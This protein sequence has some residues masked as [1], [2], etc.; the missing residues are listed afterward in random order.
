MALN[1]ADN[2]S[3]GIEALGRQLSLTRMRQDGS[4]ADEEFAAKGRDLGVGISE[5]IS[6]D[7]QG[8]KLRVDT[9]TAEQ[10]AA[11]TAEDAGRGCEPAGDI[12]TRR[13]RDS[14]RKIDAAMR[15]TYAVEPTERRRY[16]HRAGGVAAKG[17][18]A[19]AGRGRSGR[20]ARRSTRHAARRPHIGRRA[21]MSVDAGD[22]EKQFLADG[23]ARD[24]GTGGE[25][26]FDRRCMA[27]R[28]FVN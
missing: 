28:W 19:G 11:D 23:L 12:K 3:P 8:I 24:G 1:D 22:A 9:F 26:F 17:E 16:A 10:H 27:R 5:C 18:V 2:L 13:H 4:R 25:N 7:D 6:S 20:S 21:V 14:A 15:R